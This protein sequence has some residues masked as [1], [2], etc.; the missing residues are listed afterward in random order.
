MSCTGPN[1]DPYKQ[2]VKGNKLGK[3]QRDIIQRLPSGSKVVFDNILSKGPGPKL[4]SGQL[5]VTIK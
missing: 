1:G 3:D 4:Y 5:V 2:Q